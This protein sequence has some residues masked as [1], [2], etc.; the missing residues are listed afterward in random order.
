MKRLMALMVT[1]VLL[2]LTP[3]LAQEP[4]IHTF[5]GI[6]WGS[7]RGMAIGQLM[8]RTGAGVYWS[9]RQPD[10]VYLQEGF[11]MMLGMQLDGDGLC[12]S[13]D[14]DSDQLASVLC[15]SI[16]YP[17]HGNEAT[18]EMD[19]NDLAAG[20]EVVR[21]LIGRYGM[22]D[23]ACVYIDTLYLVPE[24]ELPSIVRDAA[25]LTRLCGKSS[26]DITL[27]FGNVLVE[28]CIEVPGTFFQEYRQGSYSVT[29]FYQPERVQPVDVSYHL[30]EPERLRSIPILNGEIQ[31]I[32][33][34]P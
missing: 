27:V 2:A 21:Q 26:C 32:V 15:Q 29:V 30:L 24:A 12:L 5:M 23:I 33:I 10:E 20:N 14:A 34:E 6:P 3:A 28:V 16:E 22:P 17:L 4:T 11:Y 25:L 7:A 1:C 9:D 18:D 8:A 19:L 13:F 31:F